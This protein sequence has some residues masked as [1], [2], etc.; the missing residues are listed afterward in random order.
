M[1]S[2]LLLIWMPLLYA[3]GQESWVHRYRVSYPTPA[4]A[5]SPLIIEYNKVPIFNQLLFSWN[6][7]R[8][9]KGFYTFFVQVRDVQT[10]TWG[11]VHHAADWGADVQTSYRS[12]SDGMS[13]FEHVRLEMASGK[14]A[15]G[16]R[17]QIKPADG[18]SPLD[19]RSVVVTTVDMHSFKS[20]VDDVTL[21]QLAPVCVRGVHPYSQFMLDHEHKDRLCSPTSCAMLMSFLIKKECDP[22]QLARGAYDTGLDAYGSWPFNMAACYERLLNKYYMFHTRLLSFTE[23]HSF[24]ARNIPVI[25]SVRGT[26]PGAPRPYP[27]GHL[28][29]VT[30]FD[31]KTHQVICYDPAQMTKKEVKTRY[32]LKD[33]IQAWEL[34][35]RLAYVVQIP[36]NNHPHTGDAL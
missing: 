10:G 34:S 23:L 7:P 22:C 4:S 24:L 26:V 20:E 17:I 13:S 35:R 29:V 3:D 8:P 6:A 27:H 1:K 15:N 2:S 14:N 30:G 11:T 33:F 31:P 25:V 9:D 36:K 21:A 18:V 12:P 32:H 28:L 19:I 5:K 16:F